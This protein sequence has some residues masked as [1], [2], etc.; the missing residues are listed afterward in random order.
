[1]NNL[2]TRSTARGGDGL[3][4][5]P[6]NRPLTAFD[7]LHALA[8]TTPD[9]NIGAAYVELYSMLYSL[10]E[11][12]IT[13]KVKIDGLGI[14]SVGGFGDVLTGTLGEDSGN[15]LQEQASTKVAVKRFRL[16]VNKQRKALMV[17]FS[18]I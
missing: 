10:R 3:L 7:R 1:M 15:A 5:T 14:H 2:Q 6:T 4:P 8:Q 12:D 13:A 16:M 18:Y 17:R 9:S 11:Y